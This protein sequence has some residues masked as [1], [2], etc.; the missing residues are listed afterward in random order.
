MI[1]EDRTEAG[2][3]LAREIKK[4]PKIGRD[5]KNSAV[6]SLLRGGIVVGD[7][8]SNK[9]GIP[10]YPLVV[11]KIPAPAPHSPELA[12]GALCADFVYRDERILASIHLGRGGIGQQIEKARSKQEKYQKR[13]ELEQL[14]Y[15]KELEGKNVFLVD[16]GIATGSTVRAAGLFI[17][18]N[19]PKKLILAVPVAPSE[20]DTSGFDAVFILHKD[21]YF[22]AVSQFYQSFPEVR[23]E[24]V[25]T[26]LN[27][28]LQALNMPLRQS[29]EEVDSK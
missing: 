11:A 14:D 2:E 22:S 10:H 23:D 19:K 12:I 17:K 3:K 28:K 27:S 25:R 7:V 9:L 1:F 18:S 6:V 8:I 13:F 26:I 29:T 16:D 21:P 20:F 5:F 15:E 4:D 24:E